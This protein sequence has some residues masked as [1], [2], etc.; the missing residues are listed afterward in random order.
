[1]EEEEKEEIVTMLQK[2]HVPLIRQRCSG[3]GGGEEGR[4]LEVGNETA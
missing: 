4:E 3:K 2:K 1:M